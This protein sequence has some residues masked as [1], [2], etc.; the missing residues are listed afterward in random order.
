MRRHDDKIFFFHIQTGGAYLFDNKKQETNYKIKNNK[1]VYDI[2]KH[3]DTVYTLS[4][5]DKN[6]TVA[7]YVEQWLDGNKLG[8]HWVPILNENTTNMGFLDNS[9]YY[10]FQN[11]KDTLGVKIYNLATHQ[12]MDSFVLLRQLNMPDEK[13]LPYYAGSIFNGQLLQLGQ[14]KYLYKNSISSFGFI[15]DG[16]HQKTTIVQNIDSLDMREPVTEDMGDGMKMTSVDD[17]KYHMF[18]I[19]K[20]NNYILLIEVNMVEQKLLLS[21]FELDFN[22]KFSIDISKTGFYPSDFEVIED[23][24]ETK[25]LLLS[26]RNNQLYTIKMNNNALFQ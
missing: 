8:E 1:F 7:I 16:I 25:I 14:N 3:K 13:Y 5:F 26:S 12:A 4:R 20:V 2:I 17:S 22:Y 24:G 10:V 23:N 6:D 9:S 19:K 11:I 15:Y 18:S 21:C